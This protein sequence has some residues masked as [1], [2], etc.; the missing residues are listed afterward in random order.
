[1]NRL[2]RLALVAVIGLAMVPN[3]AQADPY[4]CPSSHNFL[5]QIQRLPAPP[6]GDAFFPLRNATFSP[7]G[8]TAGRWF[9]GDV[10]SYSGAF[11]A[12][13]LSSA[14]WCTV[15]DW[16]LGIMEISYF[17]AHYGPPFSYSIQRVWDSNN[18]AVDLRAEGGPPSASACDGEGDPTSGGGNG[19]GSSPVSTMWCYF[20]DYYDEDGN[21]LYSTIAY[22]YE[23]MY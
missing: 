4:E 2:K 22:C 21:F 16:N 10:T 5:G 13:R 14:G 20:Y 9:F 6:W 17:E 12:Y 11:I 7:S 1:M 8:G 23:E 3:L 19:G 15:T 18:C